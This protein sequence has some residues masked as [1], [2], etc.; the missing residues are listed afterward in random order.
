MKREDM[1]KKMK[2][3]KEQMT[4]VIVGHVDHGKSTVIG[5][6]YA[7]T[8]SLP[9]GKLDQ[10]K[11]KCANNSKPFEYAFLLDALKDEQSQGITIDSARSF[12]KTDKRNYIIF[13][14]P[15]HIEF[16][17]NM[18]TGA[19]H[20]E[21]ALLVID[22]NEGIQENS[23]RHGYLLSL[24][25]IS[26]ISILVNKMDL[27]GY[28]EHYFKNIVSEY[29]DFLKSINVHPA[30]FIPI[31]AR[32]GDI[33]V[34]KSTNM[35]WYE[36][37]TVLEQLD[38]F[39]K[40]KDLEQKPFRF[41]IQD[42]YRFTEEDD[43]RRI[44][45]GTVKS[46][47]IKVGDNIIFLPSEKESRIK[48][49]ERF[50]AP[51]DPVAHTY[52]AIGFTIEPQVYIRPGE[53]MVKKHDTPPNVSSRFKANI[54]W[55]GRTP[56]IKNK[57]YKL[58]IATARLSVKLVEINKIVDAS[59]LNTIQNKEQVDRH[60]V[61]EAVF[62][63]VKPFAFDLAQ[64]IKGMGRFVIVDNYEIAGGGIILEA[65]QTET[66]LLERHIQ[67]REAVWDR[68]LITPDN[69]NQVFKHKSKFIV[70]CGLPNSG[71]RP[72]AK[73]LEHY[74]FRQGKKVFYLG[75][76]SVLHGLDSDVSK[77]LESRDD[78][79]RHLGE[80]ARIMTEAGQLFI[81]A[82]HDLDDYDIENL[83]LLNQPNEIMVIQV[84]EKQFNKFKPDMFLNAHEDPNKAVKE[85]S[86]FLEKNE[87]IPVEYYI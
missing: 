39:S 6:L 80:L 15:G 50:N 30:S 8:N 56:L 46:G 35:P 5:R 33:I 64:D 65:I 47:S 51:T 86:R 1:S 20:A 18:V 68:G 54:L 85:I 9:E 75:L 10:V 36:G 42:I 45:S 77:G 70:L 62:E 16:L 21:A 83:S 29:T 48:N 81:T 57:K 66:S 2:N 34:E 53:V 25:G 63:T 38:A 28:S 26:Q 87:I 12:F 52:E 82:I 59:E 61:A 73:E 79:L 84:G 17:K 43:D 72:I 78:F 32:E 4:I 19:A 27:V 58:K 7:N 23:K 49:I 74:L 55:M 41:P 71:K 69:R 67:Q 24:L 13:D 60:D 14:A 40:E 76:S 22:A 3:S 11:K 31:S 44:F 37:N